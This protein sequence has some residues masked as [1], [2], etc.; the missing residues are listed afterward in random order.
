V[1]LRGCPWLWRLLTALVLGFKPLKLT[2]KSFLQ[3]S[4][5]VNITQVH[6]YLWREDAL[7]RCLNPVVYPLAATTQSHFCVPLNSKTKNYPAQSAQKH[8]SFK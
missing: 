4:Y 2:E 6:I 3:I 8:S 1:I 5:S 7:L